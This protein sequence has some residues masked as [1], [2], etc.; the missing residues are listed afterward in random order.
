MSGD[1][2][3]RR[4]T[5][6]RL[7][8]YG[9]AGLAGAAITLRGP[10]AT[11]GP[12]RVGEV[13]D[14]WT[15]RAPSALP[16]V[17]ARA[18]S[19]NRGEAVELAVASDRDYSVEVWRAG[20]YGRRGVLRCVSATRGGSRDPNR[21]LSSDRVRADAKTGEVRCNWATTD[22]LPTD[23]WPTGL[24]LVNVRA[25]DGRDTQTIV[26]VR[27]DRSSSD[28]LYV[29]STATWQA[30]NGWGGRSLYDF[31]SH[32]AP[33][34][35]ATPRAVAVSFDR[36][37]DN[38]HAPSL[39]W[40]LRTELAL[41][42]WL[43]RLGYDLAYSDDASIGRHSASLPR[44]RAIVIGQHSEYWDTSAR[45]AVEAAAGQGV[46]IC[47]LSS[48]TCFWKVRYGEG[49]RRLVCYKTIE[50]GDAA[51]DP[52]EPTTLWRDPA[53]AE[54]ENALFGVM[55]IGDGGGGS[56]T[57]PL[58]LERSDDPLLRHVFDGAAGDTLRLGE[59]IVGWEW[60]GRV[61]NG[62]E[63]AGLR[64]LGS[65]PVN[66][67]HLWVRGQP[68]GDTVRFESAPAATIAAGNGVGV[69]HTVAGSRQHSG[70]VDADAHAQVAAYRHA[71]GGLVFAAGTN[72]W[73]LGLEP[74]CYVGAYAGAPRDG[75]RLKPLSQLTYN[76]LSAMGAR[77]HT[78]ASAPEITS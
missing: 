34:L 12:P 26:T 2:P 68:S 75:V 50:N 24:Y 17:F 43:E 53:V 3:G 22:V 39:N 30:Y 76:V 62:K 71:G 72:Q 77:A 1:F 29:S 38:A 52:V 55:Y 25:D 45:R 18:S 48:N 67:P 57:F 23:D 60:D 20:W 36:P 51:H 69:Y 73:G 65:S 28:V 7:L 33:T 59:S 5:R 15:L 49:G 41:V 21:N 63:P 31:N 13:S 14:R 35:A 64:V 4:I 6:R 27:D 54:P 16:A 19:V 11:H 9:A 10:L 70:Y 66:G 42:T 46:S 74:T 32:G 58:V 8:G 44:H 37:Y 47:S 78:L 40:P 56:L 61:A